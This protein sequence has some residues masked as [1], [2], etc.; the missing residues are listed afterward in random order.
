[1]DTDHGVSFFGLRG[2][3]FVKKRKERV[4]KRCLVWFVYAYAD[5]KLEFIR[6]YSLRGFLREKLC[7]I[8]P[9]SPTR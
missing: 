1:M 9:L 5:T 8:I 6:R 3:L 2:C 4:V 7:L